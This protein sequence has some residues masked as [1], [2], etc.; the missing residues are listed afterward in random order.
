MLSSPLS[1][2]ETRGLLYLLQE[3]SRSSRGIRE[4][5]LSAMASRSPDQRLSSR[6]TTKSM[7]T[8]H[9]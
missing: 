1:V 7:A 3:S 5:S 8:G 4:E 2:R 9:N 6:L